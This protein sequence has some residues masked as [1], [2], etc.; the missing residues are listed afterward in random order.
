MAIYPS[1]LHL[2]DVQQQYVD[3]GRSLTGV[4]PPPDAYGKAVF[5]AG[6][7]LYWRLDDAQPTT[8]HDSSPNGE[9]GIYAGGVTVNQPGGVSGTNDTA[10]AFNGSDGTVGSSDPVAGPSVYSEELWFKT[11]TNQGGKLIGFGDTQSG[12]S[13]NYDRH[14]YMEDSGQLTFGV[15][16][17]FTNTITSPSSYNDGSWHYM[18]ATQGPDGMHLYVDG[19]D[20][21]SNPQTQPAAVQR[22]LAGRRRL[23]LGRRAARSSTGRST[24]SRST[25]TS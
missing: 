19:A 16:T 11:N 2:G 12:Y 3:S 15:W 9:D 21:G 7:D 5:N 4:Q 8:A 17:G 20:V 22:L 18:V 1:V 14:V 10:A 6:P 23:R 13:S 25:A 24:R